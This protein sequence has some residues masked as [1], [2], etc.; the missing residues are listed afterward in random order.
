MFCWVLPV[1]AWWALQWQLGNTGYF[2]LP[3]TNQRTHQQC[4]YL[5]F[6]SLCCLHHSFNFNEENEFKYRDRDLHLKLLLFSVSKLSLCVDASL[7]ITCRIILQV[8]S[9]FHSH[10]LNLQVIARHV[11]P[12]HYC[13]WWGNSFTTYSNSVHLHYIRF[14]SDLLYDSSRVTHKWMERKLKVT[15][16]PH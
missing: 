7:Q 8:D 14:Q 1:F 16:G 2:Y 11:H 12:H 5:S 6:S 13:S 9:E 4:E 15:E 3:E 10:M